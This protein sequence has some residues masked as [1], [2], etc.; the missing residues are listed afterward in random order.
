MAFCSFSKDN[1]GSYTV[2][3]NKFITKYL[4]EADGFAVKVYLYG[5][6][7][8]ART[9][10]DFNI[11]SMAEVLRTTEEK[12]R[13]AFAVWEDYDLVEILSKDPFAVQYLPV[14]SAVG[15]P[16]RVRYEQ[17]AEFNKE[18]QRKMQKVG[19]FVSATDYVKYMRFLEDT[20][21]QPQALLLIAEYCINKDGKKVAPHHI[22]NKAKQLLSKGS[23]TYE[24]VE[25]A[26]SNYNANEGAILDT[27]NAM[28]IYK[29][30]PEEGDYPLYE[31]WTGP[32]GFSH[33]SI[34]TV[35]NAY[36]GKSFAYIDTIIEELS[37]KEKKEVQEVE[38][39]LVERPLSLSFT[40]R[41]ANKL[42][43]KIQNPAPYADEYVEKWKNYG[44][45]E[46]SLLDLA[47][48]CLKTERGSFEALGELVTQLFNEGIISLDAVKGYLKEKNAEL[49]LFSKV[50]E[51]CGG[52]RK[53]AANLSLIK[54]WKSWSFGDEM[55]L[56]AANRS[57]ASASPVPYM[58][59]ILA[60]WKQ[61]GVFEVKD[62]PS[63]S[64]SAGAG[65]SSSP[66]RG[67]Y[68]NPSIEAANAKAERERYY[69]RMREKALSKA[70]KVQKRATANPRFKALTTELSRME[71]SLAKAE[72][73]EPDKLPALRE[74][75]AALLAERKA[76]LAEMGITE[77][78]L[79]PQYAC[80]KCK[81]TGFLPSGEACDCYKG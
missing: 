7:L 52:I 68:V 12:I 58:N 80:A 24:Q 32:L 64:H 55:I 20:E 74:R 48:F 4:P 37:R 47:L 18:L 79:T 66:A 3:E 25:T 27:Y 13:E 46:S 42:G 9:E 73:F 69:A 70:E 45:E 60:D 35:A 71:I 36:K 75:Q 10:S 22:F 26:L 38:Q 39:Y 49:K 5:L 40:R 76:L 8:C 51:I 57:A 17:Y 81:D 21:M 72:V 43:L 34:L 54:T 41:L 11:R 19:K 61:T 2:L 33:K 50:Q 1:D 78:Q 29:D 63:S 77:A 6:Y 56:E 53:N 31:K 15:K 14:R 23:F 62:I 65:T 30:T 67:G 59:K 44:F 28:A 16:K